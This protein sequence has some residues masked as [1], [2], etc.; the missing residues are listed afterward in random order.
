M[1][2]QSTK[3][4]VAFE[5][6]AFVNGIGLG[7]LYKNLGTKRTDEFPSKITNA[8]KQIP[9]KEFYFLNRSQIIGDIITLKGK[10]ATDKCVEKFSIALNLK[11]N[12][13]EMQ[14]KLEKETSKLK[15]V[16]IFDS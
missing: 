1:K 2:I 13:E 5:R 10:Y 6:K 15:L 3:S 11:S 16:N 9:G 7:N 14:K 8:A 12:I 4:H